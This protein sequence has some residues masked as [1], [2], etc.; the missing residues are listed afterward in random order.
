MEAASSGYRQA[1]R[2]F[3]QASRDIEAVQTGRDAATRGRT[4]DTVPAFRALTPRGQGA[5]RAGYVDPLIAQTQGAAFGANKARP[6]I[7]D[8]FADEVATIAPMRTQALMQRR[9]GRENTMFQT[10]NAVTGN[11]KTVENLNDDAAFGADPAAIGQFATQ[12]IGGNIGGALRTAMGALSNGWN[13][14]TAAVREHVANVLM[15]NAQ[16]ANPRIIQTMLDQLTR[17]IERVSGLARALGR[18][19]AGGLAVA[20]G[21]TGIRR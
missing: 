20:P 6:L 17:E 3:A 2:N 15:Q 8:A 1:N 14:N 13:G 12:L 11:S 21:A 4:E 16:N 5:F 9:I 7:N 18:G 19:A 10:R